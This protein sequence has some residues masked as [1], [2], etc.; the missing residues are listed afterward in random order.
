IQFGITWD[1]PGKD[2]RY[3]RR[4][5]EYSDM[6]PQISRD[7]ALAIFRHVVLATWVPLRQ[8]KDPSTT[9]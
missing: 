2:I 7:K 6:G 9:P 8:I 4:A 5:R 1:V 3:A